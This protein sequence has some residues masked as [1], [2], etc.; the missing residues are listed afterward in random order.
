MF[1]ENDAGAATY[2]DIWDLQLFNYQLKLGFYWDLQ[3]MHVLFIEWLNCNKIE[4]MDN[5]LTQL[6]FKCLYMFMNL[7]VIYIF[8]SFTR[9]CNNN[10]SEE[11]GIS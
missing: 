2:T 4:H 11:N 9:L 10:Y 6:Y 3:T 5:M 1:V 7:E 8:I